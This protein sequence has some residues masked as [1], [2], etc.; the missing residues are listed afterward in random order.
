MSVDWNQHHH[1]ITLLRGP[2][3]FTVRPDTQRPFEVATETAVITALG[4]IFEV[5]TTA[6]DTLVTV[7]EH[8]VAITPPSA[9]NH[10]PRARLNA[11]QQAQYHPNRGLY[12]IQSIDSRQSTA[13]QRGKLILKNQPLAAVITDLNRYF[14]GKI[15][16]TDPRLPQLRVSGVFPINNTDAVLTLLETSLPLKIHHLGP[17]LTLISQRPPA[18]NK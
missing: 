3:Q 1:R 2:A 14:P 12:A 9:D 7:L 16:L 8:A 6:Q 4:T 18:N 11:G 13:W 15:V 5:Q 10:S 17:W